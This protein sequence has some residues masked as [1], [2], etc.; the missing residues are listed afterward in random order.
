MDAFVA[1]PPRLIFAA[2]CGLV[3]LLTLIIKGKFQPLIA[4]LISALGIGL[5]AG[6]PVSMIVDT[7][8]KG[9]GETL[10]GIALLVGLGSMF[11][12]ILEISGGAERVALTMIR[13][14]GEK[15]APWALGFTGMVV[16]IP[17]FFDAGLIIL[18]PLAFSIARRAKK[19]ALFF[20]IPLLAG[21]A[22]G[23]AFIPPTPGPVL[24]ANILGVDLGLVIA[25]GLVC[26][27][28]AMVLAGPVFGKICGQ[29]FDVPVPAQYLNAP[30]YDES[31][32]PSFGSVVGIIMIPLFLIL[33]NS[34][35]GMIP[36]GSAVDAL[37]PVF[38]FLGTPFI[39]LL[40]ATIVAM[41]LLGVR[42][43]YSGKNW[44]R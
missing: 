25:L 1:N 2:L 44:R 15:R 40:L 6:M 11:G 14:F 42:H 30:E 5:I 37:R 36:Q 8:N 32:L 43:G 38:T 17:V 41:F 28:F 23:H 9:M 4:I 31:K 16:A 27:F 34:V 18:I 33:I 21:L 12:A 20:V 7:V 13:R 19:S 26:G 3:I 29:K 22:V 35:L 39:A 10:K 24:V